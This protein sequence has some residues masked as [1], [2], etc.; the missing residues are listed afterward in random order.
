MPLSG[1]AVRYRLLWLR[2]VRSMRDELFLAERNY[3]VELPARG[4]ADIKHAN[5]GRTEVLQKL[6]AET[7]KEARQMSRKR[8]VVR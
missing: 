1:K 5:R 4:Y 2:L 7:T 8:R 6:I 3:G